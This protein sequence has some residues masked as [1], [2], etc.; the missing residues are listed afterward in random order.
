ML[1]NHNATFYMDSSTTTNPAL[2]ALPKPVS[3]G[4]A[5]YALSPALTANVWSANINHGLNTAGLDVSFV[6]VATG[7]E[8]DLDWKRI[9]ANNLQVRPDVAFAASALTIQATG[10]T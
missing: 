2:T 1:A 4:S 5:Y 6:E 7:E 10:K 8:V 3:L 9:D